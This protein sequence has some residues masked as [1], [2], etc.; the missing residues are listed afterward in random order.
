MKK[1]LMFWVFL[2]LTSTAIA[3]QQY[4]EIATSAQ[5]PASDKIEVVEIFWY[6]CPHCHQFESYFESWSKS[7]AEDVELKRM[8]GVLGQNWIPHAKAYYTAEAL[9][10]LDKFHKSLFHAIHN[11]KK[12]IYDDAAIKGFFVSIGVDKKQFTKIYHSDEIK[13][14]VKQAH[15]NGQEY[16]LTGVPTLIVNGKYMIS[17]STAGSFENM[18]KVTDD[19]IAQERAK[20]K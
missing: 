3:A 8:P 20:K 4:T 14:K 19:L 16:K 2:I 5:N 9:G 10:I 17:G 13:N 18:L 6:G 12:K 1:I 7:K 11:D 15:L